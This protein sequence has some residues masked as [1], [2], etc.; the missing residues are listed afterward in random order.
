MTRLRYRR[1]IGWTLAIAALFALG[2]CGDRGEPADAPSPSASAPN[3][4]SPSP[5][6]SGEPAEKERIADAFVKQA[7]TDV[8]ADRLFAELSRSV[9]AA[10]PEEIDRMLRAMDAFYTRDLPKV[11]EK[12]QSESV[13]RALFDLKVPIGKDQLDQ[14]QDPDV[15]ALVRSVTEG[16]YKLD[17]AEGYVFPVVDYAALRDLAGG[18][19]PAVRDY[20]TLMA[21]ES[22]D[23]WARD[24]ALVISRDELGRR[25]LAAEDYIRSYPDAPELPKVKER[26]LIYLRAYLFGLDNTP[27][28]DEDYKFR[29]DIRSGMEK[30]I[31]EHPDSA[32]AALSK[33]LLGMVDA[34]GGALFRK[35]QS[36]LSQDI[37]EIRAFMNEL[38]KLAEE[39]LQA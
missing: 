4:Q 27:N 37:P 29:S 10:G 5:T 26:Y 2:A 34:N 33:R 25:L 15:L 35:D 7:A 11:E 22:E 20:L 24:A 18:A 39:A 28:Y 17:A 14:I 16:G 9:A 23:R 30:F 12:F 32:A 1:R 21:Y 6:S 8:P 3:I 38:E 13:Q 36:G 19:S 31:A